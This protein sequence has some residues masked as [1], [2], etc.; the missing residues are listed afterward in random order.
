MSLDYKTS[1]IVFAAYLKDFPEGIHVSKV[2]EEFSLSHPEAAAKIEIENL[3]NLSKNEYP[4]DLFSIDNSIVKSNSISNFAAAFR[5]KRVDGIAIKFYTDVLS[6]D[7]YLRRSCEDR[8]KFDQAVSDWKDSERQEGRFHRSCPPSTIIA[9]LQKKWR[10]LETGKMDDEKILVWVEGTK[11]S[12]KKKLSKYERIKKA[13]FRIRNVRKELEKNREGIEVD[14]I[15]FGSESNNAVRVGTRLT[16]EI[17]IKNNGETDC[18]VEIKCSAAERKQV[19]VVGC[20]KFDLDI[21]M[22]ESI[23]I[24]Y[25]PKV[26][27]VIRCIISF[28]ITP[29][30]DNIDKRPFSIVRYISVTCGDP[31]AEEILKPTSSYKRKKQLGDENAFKDPIRSK[32]SS[33]FGRMKFARKLE[34]T[35][36]PKEWHQAVTGKD[37]EAENILTKLYFE[38]E[39]QKDFEDSSLSFPRH[40]KMQNYVEIF[41]KLLF[42]EEIQMKI[43][44]KQ[45]DLANVSMIKRHRSLSLHVPGIAESRPSVLKGDKIFVSYKNTNKTKCY[46]GVVDRTEM[47]DCI[48]TFPNEFQNNYLEGESVNVRFSFKR[49]GIMISHQALK[50]IKNDQAQIIFPVTVDESPSLCK[51]KYDSPNRLILYNRNLNDEQRAA[52]FGAVAS[53]ARPIPYLIYGPPG[54][55]KTVTVVEAILQTLKASTLGINTKI[56]VCAPSNAAT[57]L[58]CERLAEYLTPQQMIRVNAYSRDKKSMPQSLISFLPKRMV[59]CFPNWTN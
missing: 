38:G 3:T 40:L 50:A 51:T 1:V 53:I 55:G 52:V 4:N 20:K 54:T 24:D 9:S 13:A 15:N 5:T 30:S 18:Q 56:L 8:N 31:D 42:A 39:N 17:N 33:V 35:R 57:D 19:K 41:Q 25:I 11:N 45:Y 29:H 58:L 32:N 26:F 37:D 27:G 23:I 59:L 49:T 47:E 36:I 14:Q 44:I 48:I 46:E 28:E 43:D 21:G 6:N 16:Q 22:M 10:V 7:T 12:D 2:L 34:N